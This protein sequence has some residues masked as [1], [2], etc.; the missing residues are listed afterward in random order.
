M[1][2]CDTLPVPTLYAAA[3]IGRPS[4]ALLLLASVGASVWAA[5][6][7][8][9][10]RAQD[11]FVPSNE[12][13]N[14][15]SELLEVAVE[16]GIE[17]EVV[18][19]L[20]VG[21]LD[22]DAALLIIGPHQA[23]SVEGL[24][25][26]LRAGGRIAVA[27]D[28]G[29]SGA[30]LEA[31][32]IERHAP[33]GHRTTALRGNEALLIA[34]PNGPHALSVRVDALVTNHPAAIE[35]LELDPIFAFSES[36]ALVLAGAVGTGRLVVISDPSVFINN[37]LELGGNRRFTANLLHYL[38]ATP[39]SA[40][41]P[42]SGA[43]EE[44]RGHIILV[45]PGAP[46]VGRFGEPGADRP[47]HDLR[48]F[49]ERLGQVEVPGVGLRVLAF[50]L[51]L[52]FVLV[53]GGAL[54]RRSPYA[55]K[56]MFTPSSTFGGMAGRL[57]WYGRGHVDLLDPLLA[58]RFELETELFGRLAL[59]RTPGALELEK[60]MRQQGISP[61]E[62]SA[63]RLFL[64]ELAA[65]AERA[66]RG[67]VEPVPFARLKET[68]RRGDA[69]LASVPVRRPSSPTSPAPTSAPTQAGKA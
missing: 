61:K 22:R 10:V 7:P 6:S 68:M 25:A 20:D 44:T 48:A 27:D 45:P 26:L 67:T 21:T 52:I 64:D 56:A 15:L 40:S 49:L 29:A 13:W 58:Y 47:L 8:G 33:M 41:A 50:C 16:E 28:F 66:D 60:A 1:S 59:G 19:R 51:I 18:D 3:V 5:M 2:W 14:G 54:P 57:A 42:L 35:H 30:L 34:R 53:V 37:M 46:V 31:F 24:S 69:I 4:L 11:D 38:S 43:A 62:T 65:L 36:E 12:G 39:P 55:A 9:V 63:A 32:H 23:P 17:V